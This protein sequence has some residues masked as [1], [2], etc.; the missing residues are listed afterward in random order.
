MTLATHAIVGAAAA[1]LFPQEPALAFVAGFV[2]HFAIDAIPHWDYELSSMHDDPGN[3]LNTYITPGKEYWGDVVQVAGDAVLGFALSALIFSVWIFHLSLLIILTGAFAALVPD[4]LQ[5][6]F[7]T[8][9]SD[10]LVPL[11]RFHDWIQKPSPIDVPAWVGIGL[12][13]T[14]VA[15]IIALLKLFVR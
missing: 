2:S 4:G 10:I 11:Q 3:P 6:I 12:Q 14:L 15:A 1:S 9:H 7:F 5:F 8:W 13:C